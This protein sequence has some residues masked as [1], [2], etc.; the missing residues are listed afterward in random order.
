MKQ[1][2]KHTQRTLPGEKKVYITI[3]I[4]RILQFVDNKA[5]TRSE[6]RGFQMG[7][8]HKILSHLFLFWGLFGRF[9]S[10]IHT[11]L[12]GFVPLEKMA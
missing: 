4:R 1:Y 10:K 12:R 3:L 11:I 7:Q 5:L 6:N 8:R 2:S 9:M